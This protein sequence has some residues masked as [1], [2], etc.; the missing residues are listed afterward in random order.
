MAA[1]ENIHDAQ[2]TS[3]AE[4]AL[5]YIQLRGAQEQIA[6]A[7][8]N[9]KSEQRTAGLTRQRLA[10]GFV[11]ALDVANAEAQVATTA[12]AIPVLETSARQNIYALSVLLNASAWRSRGPTLQTRPGA[13][14]PAR[15]A[16]GIALGLVAAA[17][18]HPRGRGAMARRHRANR[19]GQ[20]RFVSAIFVDGEHQLSERP[21]AD[22]MLPVPTDLDGGAER[23]L[24]HLQGGAIAANVRLQKALTEQA[25]HHLSPNSA[26]AL[27][28]SGERPN[29][30][31]REWDHRQGAQ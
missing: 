24:A 8:D 23:Q 25:V 21:G 4:I 29:R 1:R 30:L 11:S 26:A 15:S 2:V 31:C 22:S 5:D 7:D 14:D 28:R 9:L 27:A 3:A 12:S 18:G 16:G 13:A 20:G 19:R 10:A 17:A 6:I